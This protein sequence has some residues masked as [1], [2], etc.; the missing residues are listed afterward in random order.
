MLEDCYF[1]TLNNDMVDLAFGG[2]LGYLNIKGFYKNEKTSKVMRFSEILD[3]IKQMAKKE[4][5]E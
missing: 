4:N 5:E 3:S 2:C 1:E